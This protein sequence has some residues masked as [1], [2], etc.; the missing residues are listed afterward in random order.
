[1]ID[2]II[3][4]DKEKID[5]MME[6]LKYIASHCVDV[7]LVHGGGRQA[8][9]LGIQEHGSGIMNIPPRPVVDPGLHRAETMNAMAEAA[10]SML[11]AAMEGDAGSVE[12]GFEAIGQA[13]ADGIKEYID[14]GIPPPN[15]AVTLSGGWIYNRVAKK[16]V[17][18][19]GKGGGPPLVRTGSLRD[20][21]DYE[22][23]SR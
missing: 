20:S 1:M 14:S 17:Y 5:G 19:S 16:G 3:N 7:G 6:A 8:F 4:E 11:E 23:K 9:I 22:V 21:F 10:E 13:G 2:L 12:E 18:V 15:S